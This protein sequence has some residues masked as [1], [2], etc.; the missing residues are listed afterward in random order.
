MY[1]MS[2]ATF[3]ARAPIVNQYFVSQETRGIRNLNLLR[4]DKRKSIRAVDVNRPR[5]VK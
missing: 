1:R 5:G 4:L 2:F 3:A